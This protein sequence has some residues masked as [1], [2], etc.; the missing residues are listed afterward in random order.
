[1]LG[2]VYGVVVVTVCALAWYLI[3]SLTNHQFIML[4]VA[5]GFL[6][7]RAVAL[8]SG[9]SRAVNAVIAVVI[10]SVGMLVSYY[11]ID[12]H[13]LVKE[14]GSSASVPLWDSFQF[15]RELV[16]AGFKADGSQVVFTLIAAAIAGFFGYKETRAA[17]TA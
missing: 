2:I 8:G 3:V 14:L 17:P 4:A 1:M 9:G 6:V 10:A 16:K 13:F 12:R 11:F 5:M 15:A 7:G